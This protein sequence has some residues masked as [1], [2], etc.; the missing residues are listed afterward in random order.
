MQGL[1]ILFALVAATVVA[2]ICLWLSVAGVS[3][4]IGG[5][6]GLIFGI[7]A[8]AND[9]FRAIV[10]AIAMLVAGST[11]IIV[12]IGIFRALRGRP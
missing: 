11:T 9:L 1:R 4:A 2:Y 6:V 3:Y 5:L 8:R 12:F 7:D 10:G